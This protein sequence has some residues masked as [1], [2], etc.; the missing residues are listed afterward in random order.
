MRKWHD[1][2]LGQGN[3][4]QRL[5]SGVHNIQEPH[6][7]GAVVRDGHRSPIVHQLVHTTGAKGRP[8]G[9][10]HS[11]IRVVIPYNVR[12]RPESGNVYAFVA[13]HLASID[14]RDKLA[15]AL[16]GVRTL[17]Q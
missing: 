14:V 1:T 15:L 11:L 8:D 9:V 4:D 6:D 17:L 12:T 10:R 7:S 5:G 2:Y 3:V 16:R 13:P